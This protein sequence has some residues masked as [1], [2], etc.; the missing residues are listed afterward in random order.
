MLSKSD[1]SPIFQWLITNCQVIQVILEAMGL[2]VSVYAS[3]AILP[4]FAD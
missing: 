1:T 3:I 4:L 2:R